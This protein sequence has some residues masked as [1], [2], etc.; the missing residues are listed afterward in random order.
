MDGRA[1]PFAGPGERNPGLPG[2]APLEVA[3]RRGLQLGLSR[4]RETPCDALYGGRFRGRLQ[5]KRATSLTRL[6]L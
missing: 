3:E 1:D 4:T 6:I 2:Q 5:G